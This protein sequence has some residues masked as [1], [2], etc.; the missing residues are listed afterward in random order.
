[1]LRTRAIPAILCL[2]ATLTACS[3]GSTTSAVRTD[4][5]ASAP[6]DDLATATISGGARLWVR[7]PSTEGLDA[8]VE[9]T[10]RWDEGG[11]CFLLERNGQIYGVVWPNDTTAD[12]A[13]AVV[14]SDGDAID[15]GNDILGSG[16][17]LDV[18]EDLDM[19]A[20]CAPTAGEVAVFNAD[21]TLTSRD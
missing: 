19:P 15:V 1:M 21:A 18:A 2:V 4:E 6:H 9:G 3:G 11:E 7:L 14:T 13:S 5:A 17:Y 8:P 16:G 10:L 20:E 12:A